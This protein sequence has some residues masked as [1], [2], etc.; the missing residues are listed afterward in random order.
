MPD[1]REAGVIMLADKVE[2]ATRTIQDPTEEKFRSMIHSIINSVMAD[3]QFSECPLTFQE[4]YTIA[5]TFVAVLQGI[6]HQRIEYPQTASISAGRKDVPPAPRTTSEGI[7]TLGDP[8]GDGPARGLASSGP[9]HRRR[10]HRPGLRGRRAPAEG[11]WRPGVILLGV[12]G[13]VPVELDALLE[14][15]RRDSQ[16]LLVALGRADSEL[17]ITLTD[18]AHIAPMNQRW[19]GKAGPTDVLS[20][21]QETPPGLPVDLL[22]DVVISV[23]TASRQGLERGH[24]LH[25]ELRVLLVHGLCHLLGH[26]HLVESEARVMRHEERRLLRVLLGDEAPLGLVEAALGG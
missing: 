23:Q 16:A 21:P 1:S 17:S 6:H 13:E 19:R 26:D 15:L 20:F 8:H 5:D 18:D 7:I 22:G 3:G 25:T 2:A 4:L 12:E 11:R 24:D 9:A 10:R 14:P